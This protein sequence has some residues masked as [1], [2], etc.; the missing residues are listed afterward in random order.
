MAFMSVS[1]PQ[2][3]PLNDKSA[4][5]QWIQQ[6][7]ALPRGRI[8]VR[9]RG[10][11]LHI[12]CEAPQCPP[13][14]SVVSK[15]VEAIALT[16]LDTLLP[17]NQPPIYKISLYG[18]VQ[19]PNYP[20][21]T[22]VL[23]LDRATHQFSQLSQED[24][25]SESQDR[26]D[27]PQHQELTETSSNSQIPL[28]TNLTVAC[29]H[30]LATKGH[31]QA[32]AHYLSETLS[33]LGVAVEVKIRTRK[34]SHSQSIYRRLYV[35]CSSNYSTDS[36]LLA[37]T[38]AERLRS[39]QLEGFRDAAIVS[40]V[41]GETEADWRAIADLTPREVMLREW[42]RWGDVPAIS[43]LLDR[44]LESWNVKVSAILKESTLHLFCTAVKELDKATICQAIEDLLSALAPQGIV[45]VTIYSHLLNSATP[46]W[47]D[48]IDLPSKSDSTKASSTLTLAQQGNRQALAFLLNRLLNPDLDQQL[49]TGGTRVQLLPK[50][51]LLHLMCDAPVCPEQTKIGPS[52][53]QFLRQ[54]NVPNI[55]GVRVYGRMSGQK[56]PRWN[57]GVDF[58]P[59]QRLVPEATP[60]FTASSAYVGELISERG[61]SV[62]EGTEEPPEELEIVLDRLPQQIIR[63]LQ[64]G[65][66]WSGAFAPR[67]PMSAVANLTTQT[68]LSIEHQKLKTDSEQ[69][70]ASNSQ[71]L[72][73]L[74]GLVWGML[75]LLL[76]LQVDLVV[77]N[78]LQSQTIGEWGYE[79]SIGKLDGTEEVPPS[80]PYPTFNNEFLDEH[81]G[82]YH[83][84]LQEFGPPDVLIVGSSR[85]L[86]GIN[87][88]RLREALGQEGYLNVSIYNFGVNGATARVVNLIIGR[89]LTAPQL[90]KLILWA[91]G[92]RAFNSG[93][94]DLT[95]EAIASSPGYEQLLAGSLIRPSYENGGLDDP[96]KTSG[97]NQS[98]SLIERYQRVNRFFDGVLGSLSAIYPRRDRLQALVGERLAYLLPKT[99]SD[100][101]ATKELVSEPGIVN[102]DGFLPFSIRFNPITYY[103]N[104]V[105]VS[106]DHDRDYQSFQL[107]GE[108]ADALQAI[109]AL[110]KK[111]RIP[112]V[113]VNMPLTQ[114]YL[115][116]VRGAY[117]QQFQR[118]MLGLAVQRGFTFRDITL[119][120]N[121]FGHDYF[122]DPSHLNRYGAN[123]VSEH[124]AA[125]PMIPWSAVV[126][127]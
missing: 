107:A 127:Y 121:G 60:E 5:D 126:G 11:N 105:R 118:Y 63:M 72:K 73:R 106:G 125:D 48:W 78:I 66:I 91:D 112:L 102:S 46:L 52:I 122:S 39:L 116:P 34:R 81:L 28:A 36:S 8:K 43:R 123:V 101:I 109:I 41:T 30:Q 84:F 97:D 100:A 13:Q 3:T 89:I 77:G 80:S 111:Q 61:E 27:R 54:L 37:P 53:A 1:I 47:V 23:D 114:D 75:G 12:L 21:W 90:P 58:A 15:L 65:L 38:I 42:G 29:Q 9:L 67:T 56:L 79:A 19:G 7:I 110:T 70:L 71:Q 76:V 113:F 22:Q 115:D 62:Q 31:P 26:S 25:G 40:Q 24:R 17:A 32:I 14:E 120:W 95:Y 57:Y 45:A 10:N 44:A 85:A 124:L 33:P 59:R 96:L 64:H 49:M 68:S 18:R 86:R 50:K 99:D 16:N 117:E 108:Q 98:V 2:R 92:T 104:H 74:T 83:Q 94:Q 82:R 69:F 88:A 20:E 35:L 103:Q 87:P 6:A 93:R 51:D 4:L 119:L 55:A